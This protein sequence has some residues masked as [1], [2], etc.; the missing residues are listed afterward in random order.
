MSFRMVVRVVFPDNVIIAGNPAKVV[1][2]NL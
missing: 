1:K 2:Q